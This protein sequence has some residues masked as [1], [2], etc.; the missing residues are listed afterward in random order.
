MVIVGLPDFPGGSE[1]DKTDIRGPM[2]TAQDVAE[3]AGVSRATV[4]YVMNGSDLISDAT[5]RHVMRAV[6][7][8]GY[9][10]N[11]PA[12]ALAGGRTGFIGVA[13]RIDANTSSVE[14]SPHLK[15]II[16]E[17]ERRGN[18][19][20]LI[21]GQEGLPGIRR[22]EKQSMVDGLLVYDIELHEDRLAGLAKLNLPCV[23]VGTTQ[24]ATA[25]PSVDVDYARIGELQVDELLRVGCEEILFLDSKAEDA[26]HFNF[27]RAFTIEGP[28]YARSKGVKASARFLEGRHWKGIAEVAQD[29]DTWHG[30]KVGIAVRTP[31]ILDLLVATVRAHGLVPGRDLPIVAVC[32]NAFAQQHPVSITNIDPL[33]EQ[34]STV[35]VNKLYALLDGKAS[36]PVRDVIEPELQRRES[37]AH[38]YTATLRA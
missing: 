12:R 26:D 27:S 28:A 38:P 30:R 3:L 32:P 14:L 4:S 33:A 13:V 35:A 9:H 8:L 24:D 23:L 11:G 2:V 16:S 1:H 19:V 37:T 5:K 15:T 7:K 6:E 21:P 10:P 20:L 34:C 25:L 31:A 36:G 22:I 29:I 17:T 18:N